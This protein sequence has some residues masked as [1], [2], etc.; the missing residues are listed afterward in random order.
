M[1]LGVICAACVKTELKWIRG[2]QLIHGTVSLSIEGMHD[3]GG[4]RQ[5]S[6][7]QE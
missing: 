3:E 1:R 5:V 4:T 2:W 7:R 6:Q